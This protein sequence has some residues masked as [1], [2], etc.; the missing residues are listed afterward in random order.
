MK[1]FEICCVSG[2]QRPALMD[3]EKRHIILADDDELTR[4]YLT[5][6]L[7]KAGY[8]V[9]EA[10][11]GNEA[12][13]KAFESKKRGRRVDLLLTDMMMPA[14][15]GM[16]LIDELKR[17]GIGIPVFAMT[18]HGYKDMVVEL[19][20]RGCSDYIEK[21]IAHEELL[22][23]VREFFNRNEPAAET[24][25]KE[26]IPGKVESDPRMESHIN[27]LEAQVDSAVK[28][29]R[30]L[31]R[32]SENSNVGVA[33]YN[34]PL[35]QLGGDFADVRNTDRGS[36]ILVVDVSGHD[37]GASYHAVLIDVFFKENCLSGSRNG[38]D[39]FRLLNEKLLD[40]GEN[41][42]MVTAVFLSV[43]LENMRAE[44]VSAGHP[45]FVRHSGGMAE[46][47]RLRG[48]I[49]GVLEDADFECRSFPVYSGDRFFLYTDG[50]VNAYY[51]NESNGKNIRLSEAG[52]MDMVEK[53]GRFPLEEAVAR[54]GNDVAKFS[55]YSFND[56]ILLV[57]L[58][59]P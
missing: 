10:G 55:G 8:R 45:P 17:A 42:R 28:A 52:L 44:A 43:D 35:S 6:A 47:S 9:T 15:T 51:V 48:D 59:I 36:D 49:L 21:P 2:K 30:N 20:R 37:L 38:A 58:E 57:G 5:M 56:D 34:Q 53:H 3:V 27:M 13:E 23:R 14:M 46:L 1:S 29:Y 19:M 26:D 24:G 4:R 25:G 7:E 33:F 31:T 11:N 18:A 40:S 39:F 54:I 41:E 50:L 22:D 12:L 16:E 32:I